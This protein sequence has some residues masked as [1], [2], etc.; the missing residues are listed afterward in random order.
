MFISSRNTRAGSL[1]DLFE[2]DGAV[3]DLRHQ[4]REACLRRLRCYVQLA[5]A[6][7]VE[8]VGNHCEELGFLVDFTIA[9]DVD[10]PL[11]G[12]DNSFDLQA[13]AAL[14]DRLADAG[15]VPVK[16]SIHDHKAREIPRRRCLQ[17]KAAAAA[18]FHLCVLA[19]KEQR[20][21]IA[22]NR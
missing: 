15:V 13:T 20:Y 16:F 14:D 21:A 7:H 5:V 22:R 2:D 11:W 4:I 18:N 17:I 9:A 12:V 6:F 3:L 8:A 10:L 1:P 19:I